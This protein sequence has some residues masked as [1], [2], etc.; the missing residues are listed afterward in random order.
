MNIYIP[1]PDET[2]DWS[3]YKKF[4]WIDIMHS[5][6][7]DKRHHFEGDVG[8]HVH[9]VCQEMVKIPEYAELSLNERKIVF[10]A[11][12]M[13]DI[14]KPSTTKFQEDG[15]ITSKGHSKRGSID[16]R[17]LLWKNGWSFAER[18]A[19]AILT[20]Y[21]QYPFHIWKSNPEYEIIFLSQNVSIKLLHILAEAD[22]RGRK[23]AV[24][25]PGGKLPDGPFIE[26][27]DL[28]QKSID[29]I[30]LFVE[31]AKELD[32]YE[33]PYEFPDEH[34]KYCY[35]RDSTRSPHGSFD[36]TKVKVYLMS[37]LP[38]AGKSTYIKKLQK[39]YKEKGIDLPV[40]GFDEMRADMGIEHD[41]NPGTMV[42]AVFKKAKELLA[43]QKPFIWNATN[44]S[45]LMRSKVLSLFHDYHAWIEII[46]VELNEKELRIRNRNRENAVPD[47]YIDSMLLKWEPP[48][49]SEC[50]SIKYIID[51]KELTLNNAHYSRKYQ[52]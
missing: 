2:I 46:S 49:P 39:E 9:M 17:A 6:P 12:L 24:L 34:T 8:T 3:L 29:D 37:G 42:Q 25:A 31:L 45:D 14:A 43:S 35:L 51:D 50:H 22:A 38:G 4:P 44:V 26:R 13:H 5:T 1:Q 21:H 11:A 27:P 30:A 33:K 48:L 15:S 7:Q 10:T 23:V 18:E 16:A 32:C 20:L 40:V 28:R 52:F 19:V 41:D 36:D 47:K